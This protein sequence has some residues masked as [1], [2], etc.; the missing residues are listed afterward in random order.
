MTTFYGGITT[1]AKTDGQLTDFELS[2]QYP[3]VNADTYEEEEQPLIPPIE[4]SDI[5]IR[6]TD[7]PVCLDNP[8]DSSVKWEYYQKG[9][10]DEPT[11][12]FINGVWVGRVDSMIITNLP[13][14]SK[15]YFQNRTK[16]RLGVWSDWSPI[17]CINDIPDPLPVPEITSIMTN[18]AN[19]VRLTWT[20]TK[21]L[22]KNFDHYEILV[23]EVDISRRLEVNAVILPE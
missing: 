11:A 22:I 7:N 17:A 19:Q 3:N 1:N 16:G 5:E 13:V 20:D 12:D 15:R 21:A 6:F 14:R 23:E 9:T 8:D 18:E 4:L 10:S 2:W